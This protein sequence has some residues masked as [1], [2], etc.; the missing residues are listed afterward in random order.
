MTN[1]TLKNPKWLPVSNLIFFLLLLILLLSRNS[2]II[3]D[4]ADRPN[5]IFK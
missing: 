1:F 2:C 4:I 3:A 5:T